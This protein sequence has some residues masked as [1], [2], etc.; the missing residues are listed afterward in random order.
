MNRDEAIVAAGSAADLADTMNGLSVDFQNDVSPVY[1]TQGLSGLA[2]YETEGVE[3]IVLAASNSRA[4]AETTEGAGEEIAMTD[5]E[6]AIE[7]S[8]LEM[9]LARNVNFH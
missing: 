1:G 5:N 8:T 3:R 2:H 4:L 6:G 9:P 7:Y